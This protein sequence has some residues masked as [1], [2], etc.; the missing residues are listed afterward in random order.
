MIDTIHLQLLFLLL[1]TALAAALVWSCVCRFTHTNKIN[2]RSPIRWAFTVLSVYAGLSL[3]APFA[4]A[5]QPDIMNVIALAAIT[6][7]QVSTSFYWSDGVPRPFRTDSERA[8][9]DGL[10]ELEWPDTYP[11]A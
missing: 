7:V 8:K 6:A 2:T 11:P 1:H 4:S 5:W 3:F 9:L 10:P